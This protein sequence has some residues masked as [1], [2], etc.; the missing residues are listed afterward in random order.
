MKRLIKNTS[1]LDVGTDVLIYTKKIMF[2]AWCAVK[3]GHNRRDTSTH[4]SNEDKLS[5]NCIVII[6]SGRGYWNAP[7]KKNNATFE[8]IKKATL[9]GRLMEESSSHTYKFD[10]TIN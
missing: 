10:D 9:S 4:E 2:T 3:V 7:T 8:L 5:L 6:I 1:A